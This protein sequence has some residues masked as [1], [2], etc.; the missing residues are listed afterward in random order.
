MRATLHELAYRCGLVEHARRVRRRNARILFILKQRGGYWG[1]NNGSAGTGLWNSVNFLVV[2]LQRLGYEAEMVEV[3]DNNDIDREVTAR[4]PTHVIIEAFWVVPEKFPVLRK[5]HP[6]VRWIVRNHSEMPFLANEGISL[7]WA[8]AYL[9]DGVEVMCNSERAQAD[10]RSIASAQ[11]LRGRVSYGPNVYPLSKDGNYEHGG[12]WGKQFRVF[13]DI[14]CFGAIRPLKNNLAQAIAAQQFAHNIGARLRFHINGDRC[15]GGGEP[16]LK[17]LR[18]LLGPVLIEH[19]WMQ[20]G[21]FLHTMSNMNIS[22]QVSFSETFNIVTADAVSVNVPAVVSP[23]VSWL[24][25]YAMADPTS[26]DSMVDALHYAHTMPRSWRARQQRK[27]LE[28][29]NLDAE[30]SWLERFE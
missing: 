23:E 24:G 16:I 15:E 26:V 27:D 10:L 8:L 29:W 22:M 21:I 2:A 12:N 13:L 9:K 18:G 5:L 17:S 28:R 1:C 19:P 20:R 3:T 30:A 11:G 4:K 25:K 14:G 6:K 7:Q